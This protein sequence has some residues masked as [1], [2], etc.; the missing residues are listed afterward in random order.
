MTECNNCGR[1]CDPVNLPKRVMNTILNWANMPDPADAPDLYPVWV[2]DDI[3]R[4]RENIKNGTFAAAWWQEYKQAPGQP[5]MLQ[6]MCPW[7]NKTTHL[8]EAHSARPPICSNYPWY[9][10]DPVEKISRGD[11]LDR[12]CSY[13]EDVPVTMRPTN[14]GR[15]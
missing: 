11:S 4:V 5:H 1:C 15:P 13:W 3:D 8:C 9:G 14:W 12:E 2:Y 6:V 10:E 7:Y